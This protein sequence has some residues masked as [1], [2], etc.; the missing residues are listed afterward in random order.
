[1][2][3][4]MLVAM[5]N[6]F[7]RDIFIPMLEDGIEWYEPKFTDEQTDIQLLVWINLHV[8]RH[9]KM[10]KQYVQVTGNSL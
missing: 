9:R 10:A 7:D 3:N 2:K 8:S 4:L 5:W 6:V 1:M